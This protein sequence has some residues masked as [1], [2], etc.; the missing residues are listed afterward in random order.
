MEDAG[1]VY[2]TLYEALSSSTKDDPDGKGPPPHLQAL[3]L[4]GLGM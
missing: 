3:C 2:K 1:K 4:A